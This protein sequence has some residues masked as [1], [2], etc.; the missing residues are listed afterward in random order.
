MKRVATVL[1]VIGVFIVAGA[2]GHD[3]VMI[4][5]RVAYPLSE[6]LKTVAIGGILTVPAIIRGVMY[7]T[8]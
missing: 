5:S 6:T 8:K 4:A 1:A 2:L 7:G 3:D